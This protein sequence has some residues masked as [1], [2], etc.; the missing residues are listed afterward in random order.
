MCR[1]LGVLFCARMSAVFQPVTN[2]NAACGGAVLA[3]NMIVMTKGQ[4]VSSRILIVEDDREVGDLL[5]RFLEGE[6]FAVRQARDGTAMDEA[7]ST[8]PA[9]FIILDIML[10]GED[11][12]SICRRLRATRKTPI[13]M[14]TAKG[15][16]LDRIVGLEVGA[17]DY[18]AKPFHPR[19]LLARIRAVLRRVEG[20]GAAAPE[21]GTVL[22]FGDFRFEIDARRLFRN[23]KEIDLSGGDFDLLQAFVTH[24]RR[25]LTR[26]QLMNLT[27]GEDWEA[28]DR[29]V[30]VALSRLRRK[31]EDDP[32]RPALIRTVRS[33][34]YIFTAQIEKL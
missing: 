32:S 14:L 5:H 17:D 25:L 18:L 19:E 33:A 26:N 8:E 12:I 20:G 1:R 30:D 29:S 4:P 27:R 22:R 2:C 7:L 11:G 34:G 3:Q 23:G 10:P 16:E 21:A 31:L 15:D 9:D 6:G 24:P 13:L 28:F